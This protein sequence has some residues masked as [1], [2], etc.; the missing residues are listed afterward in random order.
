MG[1][2]EERREKGRGG[3]ARRWGGGRGENEGGRAH[4][5]RADLC[6]GAAV[7]RDEVAE[8]DEARPAAPPALSDVRRS[9]PA[10]R[11]QDGGLAWDRPVAVHVHAS[12]L[13]SRVEEDKLQGAATIRSDADRGV[14]IGQRATGTCTA[15]KRSHSLGAE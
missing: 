7:A 11:K 15:E 13:V 9:A 10:K 6:G 2:G 3:G 4:G 1:R 12:V 14:R 8:H 5:S